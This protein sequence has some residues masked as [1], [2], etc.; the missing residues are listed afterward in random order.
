MT[1][2]VGS[3]ERS[4]KVKMSYAKMLFCSSGIVLFAS[5]L[6]NLLNTFYPLASMW[7]TFLEYTGYVC[8]GSTLGSLG[9]KI[10]T[11]GCGES[12][13]EILD[14]RLSMVLSMV[15]IFAFVMARALDA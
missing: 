10:L 8:W 7:T 6:A 12:P 3:E 11:W 13:E 5:M 2:S 14:Q 9:T 1:S 15:G 4:M